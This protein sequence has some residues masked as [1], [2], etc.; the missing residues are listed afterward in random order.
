M[1]LALSSSVEAWKLEYNFEIGEYTKE[2]DKNNKK[3][4]RLQL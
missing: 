1:H 3:N 4:K 2:T